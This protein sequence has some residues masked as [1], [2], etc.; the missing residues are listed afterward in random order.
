MPVSSS[1]V[2]GRGR[3]DPAHGVGEGDPVGQGH[4]KGEL[5]PGGLDLAEHHRRVLGQGDRR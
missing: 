3:G 4:R 1:W 5:P 2:S